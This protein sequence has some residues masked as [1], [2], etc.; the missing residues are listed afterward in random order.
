MLKFHK[1]NPELNPA[2]I[3]EQ[4]NLRFCYHDMSSAFMVDEEARPPHVTVGDK[5]RFN[6]VVDLLRFLFVWEDDEE[7]VGW[8][9]KPYRIIL[10]KT[11]ELL[12][13]R[14]GTL[15]AKRWLDEFFHLV[16]LTDFILPYPTNTVFKE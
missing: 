15:K 11:F 10:Q 8:G 16:R 6:K 4:Q 2:M 3:E 13:R 14:L 5:M 7:R 1:G 12:D 9:N